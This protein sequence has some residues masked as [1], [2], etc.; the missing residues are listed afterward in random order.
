MAAAGSCE[1]LI[2]KPVSKLLRWVE[3]ERGHKGFKRCLGTM[4]VPKERLEELYGGFSDR[5]KELLSQFAKKGEAAAAAG[6]LSVAERRRLVEGGVEHPDERV[7]RFQRLMARSASAIQHLSAAGAL[8]KA[9]LITGLELCA[10]IIYRIPENAALA[11][12]FNVQVYGKGAEVI[13]AEHAANISIPMGRRLLTVAE[14]EARGG[15]IPRRMPTEENLSNA[16]VRRRALGIIRHGVARVTAKKRAEKERRAKESAERKE[17]AVSTIR[18]GLGSKL[19][20]RLA[21]RRAPGPV[22]ALQGLAGPQARGTLRVTRGPGERAVAAR[23]NAGVGVPAGAAPLPARGAVAGIPPADRAA[24]KFSVGDERP[25]RRGNRGARAG[26]NARA[27]LASPAGVAAAFGGPVAVGRPRSRA[28]S[29]SA[30]RRY[31]AAATNLGLRE[32]PARGR[33]EGRRSGSPVRARGAMGAIP[34][35]YRPAG[36]LGNAAGPR[37]GRSLGAVRGL[38]AREAAEGAPGVAA[39]LGG[40]IEQRGPRSRSRSRSAARRYV[41]ANLGLGVAPAR[42]RAEGRR[43]GSPVR[44]RGAMGAVPD[45]YRLAGPLGNAAGPR[46]GRS[47]GAVRE[48]AAREAAEGAPGVATALGGPVGQARPRSRAPSRTRRLG[49]RARSANAAAERPNR[50]AAAGV[51]RGSRLTRRVAA[52]IPA[53]NRAAG[54]AHSPGAGNTR[55]RARSRSRSPIP[56]RSPQRGQPTLPRGSPPRGARGPT[57][58]RLLTTGL[59]G[60][61]ALW[62]GRTQRNNGSRALVP[63]R[64]LNNGA[65]VPYR[66]YYTNVAYRPGVATLGARRAAN[67]TGNGGVVP[68][69]VLSG[70]LPRGWP[71]TYAAKEAAAAAAWNRGQAER[72]LVLTGPPGGYGLSHQADPGLYTWGA[73]GIPT[74]AGEG[75]VVNNTPPARRTSPKPTAAPAPPAEEDRFGSR[76][77][78]AG[79]LRGSRVKE[80]FKLPKS[81]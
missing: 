24:L 2:T 37:R 64:G 21:L 42:G 32:A 56:N 45:L 73:A 40:P 26:L 54:S 78:R 1:V 34:N 72:G 18:R 80:T 13:P 22:G 69:Y 53:A 8:T 70:N 59:A 39:A 75:V 55:R 31:E 62:A 10:D 17:R 28:H 67:T 11:S 38:A 71:N 44:A 23:P 47:L 79:Q 52:D 61:G 36:A 9:Q 4:E 49:Y 58:R 76:W 20:K 6:E 60:L 7:S 14:L 57:L 65:T 81:K 16:A 77:R 48:L 68:S 5:A 33:A 66:G 74:N 12:A 30:A 50:G 15:V 19:A 43:S 27:P 46:R 63:Y 51:R 41:A 29:R 35:L 3:S 25:A